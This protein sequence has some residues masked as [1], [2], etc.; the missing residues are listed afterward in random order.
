MLLYTRAKATNLDAKNIHVKKP[1]LGNGFEG[2][3]RKGRNRESIQG[4]EHC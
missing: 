1:W 4:L 2:Y 3:M